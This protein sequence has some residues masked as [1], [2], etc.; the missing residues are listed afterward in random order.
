MEANNYERQSNLINPFAYWVITGSVAAGEYPG[1]QFSHSIAT[2]S[3]TLIHSTRALLRSKN[4][5][6]NS[7]SHKIKSL[8]DAGIRTFIDLTEVDER[9]DYRSRLHKERRERSVNVKYHRFPIKDKQVPTVDQMKD[10]LELVKSEIA[11]GGKVYIHCF[12]GLGRTGLTVGCLIKEYGLT[13][14]DPIQDIK[15]MR[16]GLAGDF[17]TSPETEA[18]IQFVVDWAG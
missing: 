7:T 10:I 12:R 1:S 2:N 11:I 13:S 17:R 16:R 18:Q 14:G 15:L 3:A 6:M 4:P 5:F 8:L 9:P